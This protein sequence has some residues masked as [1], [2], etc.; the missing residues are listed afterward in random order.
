M[1]GS[2][3]LNKSY[4]VQISDIHI[5]PTDHEGH[6]TLELR[7]VPTAR[8]VIPAEDREY[9]VT[10]TEGHLTE[11]VREITALELQPAFV[12]FTGDQTTCGTRAEI[13][14]FL[15]II[16]PLRMPRYCNAANHDLAATPEAFEELIGPRR[17][18]F[19]HEGLRF[20]I[21]DEYR[22]LESGATR[23]WKALA[24]EEHYEWLR[25]GL[26]GW[27]GAS[28]LVTHAPILPLGGGRYADVWDTPATGRFVEFL[29]ETGI[30]WNI[31]GHWHRNM[32]WRLGEMTVINTGALGGFQCSGPPPFFLFAIRP[33]YRI[34]HWDGKE[35]H[36]HWHNLRAWVEAEVTSVGGE[37]VGGPRPQVHP[38]AASGRTDLRAQAYA[39]GGSI[40][41]VEW[42][43]GK[44]GWGAGRMSEVKVTPP[45]WQP[46]RLSWEGLW[47]EW[48]AELDAGA[49]APGSYVILTR[50]M[51]AG[52]TDW[53]GHD[54]VPVVVG[55]ATTTGREGEQL[56][57]LFRFPREG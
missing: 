2:R 23:V 12:L 51:R 26:R 44:E 11:A 54:A 15:E 35:L 27:T 43:L 28:V 57:S 41:A 4:F 53:Q 49:F 31:T 14:T 45:G 40:Q 16:E 3:G 47:S 22:L 7:S 9:L 56:F 29:G 5:A 25:D 8:R 37:S 6:A 50:A 13:E 30:R 42:A 32:R 46:M 33:G 1:V 24:S 36:S 17:V 21:M 55:E 38:A 10:L 48:E 39:P 34:F 20:F 19:D 18:R 52:D